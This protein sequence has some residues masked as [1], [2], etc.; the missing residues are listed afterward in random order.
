MFLVGG[1]F[2]KL[3]EFSKELQDLLK[4]QPQFR[5]PLSQLISV[6]QKWFNKKSPFDPVSYGFL[7]AKDLLEALPSLIQVNE[8]TLSI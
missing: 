2:K 6:Y 4:A 8:N 1:N 5:L 7:S 3:E